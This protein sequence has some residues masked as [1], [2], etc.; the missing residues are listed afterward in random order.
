VGWY[1]H[2]TLTM[3]A[4]AFL[5]VMAANEREKGGS[6]RDTLDL[7][8]LTPA[9]IRRLLAARPRHPPVSR[10][11]SLTWSAWRRRHKAHARRC[12]HMRR[13][14]RSRDIPA[15]TSPPPA[16]LPT[17]RPLTRENGELSL[18]Y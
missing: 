3:L 11:H 5:S 7:V 8:D 12:R 15:N 1:R 16:T 10:D 13:A 14:T 9:E 18:E 4:Y 17:A 2:I 6:A